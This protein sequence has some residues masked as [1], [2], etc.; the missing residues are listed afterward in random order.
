MK[1][2]HAKPI[3]I[4]LLMLFCAGAMGFVLYRRRKNA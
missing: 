2:K 4:V 1:T 3:L